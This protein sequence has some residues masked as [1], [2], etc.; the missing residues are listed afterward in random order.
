MLE[1]QFGEEKILLLEK[2]N[3]KTSLKIQYKDSLKKTILLELQL[4]GVT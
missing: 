1:L 4:Q 3:C 2:Y